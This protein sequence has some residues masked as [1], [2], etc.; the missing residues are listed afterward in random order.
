MEV[1]DLEHGELV[2]GVLVDEELL[3]VLSVVGI[4]D[5][6]G[7]PVNEEG[8]DGELA[9]IALNVGAH[10]SG[11]QRRMTHKAERKTD[12]GG[13]AGRNLISSIRE[14]EEYERPRTG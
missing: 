13:W 8:G 3:H 14:G 7:S 9:N 2:L 5:E 12:T 10:L 1:K 6:V 4:D 11:C